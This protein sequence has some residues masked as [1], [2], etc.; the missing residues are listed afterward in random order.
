MRLTKDCLLT[1]FLMAIIYATTANHCVAAEKPRVL[2]LTDI[3]NEPDDAMSLV[4][5]LTYCNQWEVEGL[6][7]TT[8]IHQKNKTAAWRIRE[9]VEA[10]GQVRNNLLIHEPGY[11]T[12]NHLVAVIKEGLPDYGMQAVGEGK[13]SPGSE[14][15][16]RAVDQNDPR[17]IWVPV[18]GGPN[19]LAQALWKVRATRSQAAL[20][21]F[22]SK[23]RVY[24][25]FRPGRQRAV[26]SQE[27]HESLLCRQSGISCAGRLSQRHLDGH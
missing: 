2:V 25:D 19:V 10:Y 1:V 16:I 8:S 26:D 24:T 20:D 23:I 18:W 7:A 22:V 12:T 14:L 15:V 9:I 5:F 3:E 17:P 13:D 11:P 6:V 27:L 21:K 4:R